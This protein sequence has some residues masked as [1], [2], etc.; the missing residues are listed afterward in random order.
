M[1]NKWHILCFIAHDDE[2]RYVVKMRILKKSNKIFAGSKLT[3][4][5]IIKI[6]DNL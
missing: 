4:V 6:I 5:T 1:L 3:K 2:Q